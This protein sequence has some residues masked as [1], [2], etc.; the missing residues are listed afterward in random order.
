MGAALLGTAVVA[1][2]VAWLAVDYTSTPRLGATTPSD[3]GWVAAEPA[4]DHD[5]R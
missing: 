1:G 5:A 4:A 3:N 2:A